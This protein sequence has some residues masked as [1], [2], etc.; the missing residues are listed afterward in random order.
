MNPSQSSSF[1]KSKER[2]PGGGGREHGLFFHPHW[3]EQ[4]E[5]G[6]SVA[7]GMC[8]T[9]KASTE[10]SVVGEQRIEVGNRNLT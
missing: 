8:D 5:R 3:A 2:F 7:V 4:L 1:W 6:S 9:L 10:C